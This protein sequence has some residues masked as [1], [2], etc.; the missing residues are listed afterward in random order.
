MSGEETPERDV[1]VDEAH[2]L[3]LPTWQ[4]E[5]ALHDES[6]WSRQEGGEGEE[7]LE[8]PPPLEPH[9]HELLSGEELFLADAEVGDGFQQ[10][11][12]PDNLEP[13]PMCQS[14]WILWHACQVEMPGGENC[15]RSPTMMTTGNLC[16]KYGH[17]SMCQR[18]KIRHRG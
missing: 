7:E 11:L 14:D 8:C 3:P 10:T 12:M 5:R 9:L 13:S 4:T 2:Q 6:D 15:R 1:G 17:H 18:H 16:E